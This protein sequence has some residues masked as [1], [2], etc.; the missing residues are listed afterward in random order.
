MKIEIN[1][2]NW[3]KSNIKTRKFPYEAY[4]KAPIALSLGGADNEAERVLMIMKSM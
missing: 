1:S 2:L 4:Y 3:L